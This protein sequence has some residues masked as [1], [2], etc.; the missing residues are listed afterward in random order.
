MNQPV[1]RNP[2]WRKFK[3]S[4]R[5][6]WLL[7][8]QFGWPLLAFSAA[9]IG[10]GTLY[11]FLSIKA[12]ETLLNPAEGMYI[13]LG[14]T[15]LQPIN[16][17]PHAW[18]LEIY[19]FIMPVVGIGILAQGVADFGILFFNR[20][21]RGKEWEMAVA[22]TLSQHVIL[23]GLGHLGYRVV[24]DLY[25]MDRDVVVIERN[26]SVDLVANVKQMD[27]PVIQE[28]ASREL[29]LKEAGIERALAIVL[30]TQNDSLN[31]QIA[32]KARSLNPKIHV[33]VRIFDGEFAQALHDQFG[34]TAMSATGMAAPAFAA[35]AA[36]VDITPPI[37]IEGESLSLARLNVMSA[38]RLV[39]KSVGEIEAG[40]D[41]SIVLLH[42]LD[43]RDFHPAAAHCLEAGDLLAVLGGPNQ[44]NRLIKANSPVG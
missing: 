1:R 24:R 40:F 18:F 37:T 21:S 41:L 3:A 28:D 20:R 14:L 9:I 23:V 29:V 7:V 10:G 2:R 15:F 32:L 39:G 6:T 8:R 4:L 44:I 13:V 35:A 34:F 22:S 43:E 25:Q 36:G 38:S 16:Q 31:L 11:Y 19:Y 42:H 26:P 12:G 17:F 33:I 5:D 30:C 27:I